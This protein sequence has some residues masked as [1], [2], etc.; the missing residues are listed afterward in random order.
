MLRDAPLFGVGPGHFRTWFAEKQAEFR[1]A[2]AAKGFSFPPKESKAHNDYVQAAAETGIAGLGMLLWLYFLVFRTGVAAVIRAQTPGA[3]AVAGGMVGGCASL[4]VDSGFNF[5]FDIIP[6]AMV[7]WMFAGCLTVM[8]GGPL[9]GVQGMAWN[10]PPAARRWGGWV[11]GI[12]AVLALSWSAWPRI[13]SDRASAEGNYYMDAGMW[14][15]SQ[16]AYE[17]AVF[18]TPWDSVVMYKL[19]MAQEKGS[20]YD[21]TGH[22]WDRAL[23]SYREAERLGMRDELLYGRMALVFEKKGSPRRAAE[24]G[25]ESLRIFPENADNLSNQAYWLVLC[26]GKLAKALEYSRKA[27]MM[28]PNHPMYLW[29]HGLVLEKAGKR[30]EALSQMELALRYLDLFPNGRA[31]FQADLMKDIARVRG[32]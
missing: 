6:A 24:V 14:E 32:R 30:R 15:M 18:W 11:A 19:G 26:G 25:E 10:I 9:C 28:V 17:R 4:A 23:H 12:L 29:T 21:W 5:P 2:L 3:G 16:G 22:A 31:A 8:A 27:V 20:T 1:P 13:A 7:F